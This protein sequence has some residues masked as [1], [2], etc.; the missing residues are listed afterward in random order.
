V[1]REGDDR[2]FHYDG[3]MLKTQRPIRWLPRHGDP[4]CVLEFWSQQ[5][6]KWAAYLPVYTAIVATLTLVA[7]LLDR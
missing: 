4:T 7:I 6:V 2:P 3:P 1:R 5:F